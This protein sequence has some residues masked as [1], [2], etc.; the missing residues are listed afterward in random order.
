MRT[1]PQISYFSYLSDCWLVLNHVSKV[2]LFPKIL[3][4]FSCFSTVLSRQHRVIFRFSSLLLIELFHKTCQFGQAWSWAERI[5][6]FWWA[7]LLSSS[8]G[9]PAAQETRWAL[10]PPLS[11]LVQV[12]QERRKQESFFLSE[13]DRESYHEGVKIRTTFL[14]VLQCLACD[15]REEWSCAAAEFPWLG[16]WKGRMCHL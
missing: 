4:S 16:R 2:S 12:W 10:A 11:D 8:G 5:G 13:S 7:A 9:I 15:L 6:F 3:F 1:C 14:S